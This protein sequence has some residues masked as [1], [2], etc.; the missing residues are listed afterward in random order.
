MKR[1]IQIFEEI[2]RL[3]TLSK[4]EL[5]FLSEDTFSINKDLTEEDFFKFLNYFLE[6]EKMLEYLSHVHS[7]PYDIMVKIFNKNQSLAKN[8]IM[9]KNC[10][11]EIRKYY[12]LERI[13]A[14]DHI[15]YNAMK[16]IKDLTF[17]NR[18]CEKGISP[19]LKAAIL[20]NPNCEVN[21]YQMIVSNLNKKDSNLFSA[22]VKHKFSTKE[23][24]NKISKLSDYVLADIAKKEMD[25]ET[26]EYIISLDSTKSSSIIFAKA[27]ILKNK[28]V[29]KKYKIDLVS[30]LDKHL[31]NKPYLDI[32]DEI[33]M[34]RE[35][36]SKVS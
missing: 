8:L 20:E 30:E 14:P 29:D 5:E 11:E 19:F 7:L 26:I 24:L 6:D 16:Q 21:Q 3:T 18:F 2:L 13:N 27:N 34:L 9:N 1:N 15:G 31:L 23:V 10:P 36:V 4:E 33:Y 28:T 12:I 25:E 22:L 32:G 35:Y 17:I